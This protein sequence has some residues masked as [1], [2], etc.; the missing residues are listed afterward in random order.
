MF[1]AMVAVCARLM[2]D[3]VVLAA[4]SSEGKALSGSMK[5]HDAL[6]QTHSSCCLTAQSCCAEQTTDSTVLHP[7]QS[8]GYDL[9]RL[10]LWSAVTHSTWLMKSESAARCCRR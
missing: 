5:C 8:P 4:L 3:S 2:P 7:S 1:K 10:G 6:K 9:P